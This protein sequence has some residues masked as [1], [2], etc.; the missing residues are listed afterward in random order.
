[1]PVAIH[2]ESAGMKP[3]TSGDIIIED[4]NGHLKS[5]NTDAMLL[6]KSLSKK[7]SFSEW[8]QGEQTTYTDTYSAIICIDG[9]G[10]AEVVDSLDIP[11]GYSVMTTRGGTSQN[12]YWKA[13]VEITYTVQNPKAQLTRVSGSWT[14]LRGT[15]TLSNRQVYYNQSP[16]GGNPTTK[17]PTSNTFGYGTGFSL[18]KVLDLG[19]R[20]T[21]TITRTG[22]SFKITASVSWNPS[23]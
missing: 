18:A 12:V 22:G 15:S 17:Y 4:S 8:L 23:M 16:Y 9:D 19:C 21:A 20:S 13:T 7:P 6:E 11:S 2:A 5:F 10:D 1:M 3:H 14:Q